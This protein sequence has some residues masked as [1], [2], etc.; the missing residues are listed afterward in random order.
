MF[1]KHDITRDTCQLFGGQARLGYDWWWH[2]L[3]AHHEVTG[4]EKAFFIEFFVCNP[5]R[6]GVDPVFGQLPKNH[7]EGILPSYLMVKCGTWG[8]D[9]RQMHRFFGWDLIRVSKHAPIRIQ[10]GDCYVSENKIHGSVAVTKEDAAEHPEWMC[11]AGEMT[12]DLKIDK[13]IA[14]NVGYGA[15]KPMRML[16]LF[17]MFWHAEGMKTAYEGKIKYNG[18]TYVVTPETCYGYAD[19]NWGKD[20]TSPWVWLSSNDLVS[21]MTGERLHDSV[22][23]IGGG[24]PKVGPVALPRQLLSAFYYEGQ[25]FEFNFSK[26][27]TGCRTIFDC[28][29][30]DTQIIWHVD[31]RTWKK[32]MVAD[33]TCEKKDMLLINYEAP[34]GKKLHNRLWNGGNGKGTIELY[35]GGELIDRIHAEHIGCEYGEYC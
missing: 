11:D 13:K 3:T 20:F 5:K 23:D 15:S 1:Q 14:Y 25:E 29:E 31:Q 24:C 4:E 22:F 18:E 10:A 8:E 32:R 17:E 27:W 30:T 28:R 35:D 6:G 16:Q 9:A 19:K 33:I 12:F 2:S 7:D 26:F 21:E 34:N